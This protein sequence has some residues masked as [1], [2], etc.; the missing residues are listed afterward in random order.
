MGHQRTHGQRSDDTGMVCAR[1]DGG[2]GKQCFEV[3]IF[4]AFPI[5][6]SRMLLRGRSA[7]GVYQGSEMRQL[8]YWYVKPSRC[9]AFPSGT[10]KGIKEMDDEKPVLY[11]HYC[12][13][14]PSNKCYH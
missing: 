3:A 13:R 10:V 11:C 7:N 12:S 1:G 9:S 2:A 4:K 14:A 8:T 5:V 6:S